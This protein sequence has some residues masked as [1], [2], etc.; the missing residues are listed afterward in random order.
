MLSLSRNSGPPVCSPPRP[1]PL[2]RST[3]ASVLESSLSPL[4]PWPNP[5]LLAAS[6]SLMGGVERPVSW[7]R[8]S[9]SCDGHTL[10]SYLLWVKSQ[11]FLGTTL[12]PL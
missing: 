6:D 12:S 11:T 10:M 4:V 1:P 9:V 7:P 2:Q 5:E 3:A 8:G